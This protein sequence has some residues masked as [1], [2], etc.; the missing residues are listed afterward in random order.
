MRTVTIVEAAFWYDLDGIVEWGAEPGDYL[1]PA[2]TCVRTG[3]S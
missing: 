1:L 2:A 3:T